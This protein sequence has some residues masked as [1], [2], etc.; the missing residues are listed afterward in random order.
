MPRASSPALAARRSS[1]PS[2]SVSALSTILNHSIPP[3]Y[4]CYLLKSYNVKRPHMT[5]IGSTPDPPRRFK[6][7]M[8]ERIGGALKT[9]FGRPWEMEAIVHGFPSKLQALQFEWCWQNPESSRLLRR[10]AP[11]PNA[12]PPVAPKKRKTTS[13]APSKTIPVFPRRV[14]SHRALPRIQVLQYMLTVPP[15]SRFDLSVTLFS[16]QARDWWDEGRRLGPV[17]RT[18]TE[19]KKWEKRRQ[20]GED[21]WGEERGRK[22]DSVKVHYREEGVDGERLVRAKKRTEGEG[23]ERMRVDDD[24]FFHFHWDKFH[25]LSTS[26]DS[27]DCYI[28]RK[29]VDTEDHLSFHLCTALPTSPAS[30]PCL[31]TFHPL[32]L[33]SHFLSPSAAA[34]LSTSS[35]ILAPLLPATSSC[36]SC[37]ADLHWTDLVRGMYRRKEESEGRRK[38]RVR[39]RIGTRVDE[40]EELEDEEEE[41]LGLDVGRRRASPKKRAGRKKKKCGSAS[42]GEESVKKSRAKVG[43]KGKKATTKAAS[44][45]KGTGKAKAASPASSDDEEGFYFSDLPSEAEDAGVGPDKDAKFDIDSEVSDVERSFVRRDAAFDATPAEKVLL[46]DNQEDVDLDLR[47]ATTAFE[48]KKPRSKKAVSPP[49]PASPKRHARSPKAPSAPAT[50]SDDPPS[51]PKKR[52]TKATTASTSTSATLLAS[53][54]TTKT[55]VAAA[56]PK[57]R[58]AEDSPLNLSE[59]E[60]E[61]PPP[62]ALRGKA[63]SKKKATKKKAVAYVELSD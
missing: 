35:P 13:T 9:R 2:T 8:G 57:G 4:A 23:I 6:Q 44:S 51:P 10:P 19:L 7:H 37:L 63:V 26:N 47:E 21:A 48:P 11:P 34:S 55:S 12:D 39:Q 31:A 33:S 16:E 62:A 54:S 1:N 61:L 27:P 29:P 58:K 42:S 40:D 22:L 18:E 50:L 5:Y 17:V 24:D 41:E 28:C 49:A 32:C 60:E 56:E 46:S 30:P 20:E 14:L 38:R 45:K 36:P 15:W 3:F 43:A 59:S 53:F 25:S 52:R